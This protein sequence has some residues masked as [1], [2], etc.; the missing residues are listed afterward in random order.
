MTDPVETSRPSLD[1]KR[2]PGDRKLM[3]AA[4]FWR[5]GNGHAEQAEVITTIA[6]RIKFRPKSVIA[7][8]V[9]KKSRHLVALPAISEAVAARLLVAYHIVHQR[10]MM[11]RFLDALGVAH[12]DG[13]IAEEKLEPI[14]K[15]RLVS[16]AKTLAGSY[17]AEDVSLYFSTLLW[18]DPE[19][20]GALSGLAEAPPVADPAP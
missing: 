5:D 7:M 19:T 3:A 9:E 8:S 6:N 2:L 16:A 10:P 13:L 11:G 1:W 20:W 15:E 14:A 18:Q 4:A 12:E 17:P